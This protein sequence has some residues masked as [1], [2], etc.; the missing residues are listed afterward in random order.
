MG[1][2]GKN[3]LITATV[4]LFMVLGLLPSLVAGHGRMTN[5]PPR[6]KSGDSAANDFIGT[7]GPSENFPCQGLRSGAIKA[8]F[9]EGQTIPLKWH[10]S[11]AHDG[12]CQFELSPTGDSGFQNG[13]FISLLRIEKCAETVGDFERQVTLPQGVACQ[14]CTMRFRWLAQL[15]AKPY[16]NCADVTIRPG[17]GGGGGGGGGNGGNGGNRQQGFGQGQ[18]QQGGG[19]VAGQRGQFNSG[20]RQQGRS[21]R[22]GPRDL[23]ASE[24]SDVEHLLFTDSALDTSLERRDLEPRARRGGRKGGAR[25][26]GGA[27]GKKKGGGGGKKKGGGGGGAAAAAAKRKAAAANAKKKAAAAAAAKQKQDAAKNQGGNDAAA[28]AGGDNGQLKSTNGLELETF[29]KRSDLAERQFPGRQR[30]QA[31][32]AKKTGGAARKAGGAARKAGGGAGGAKKAAAGGKGKK[33]GSAG[34]KAKKGG[35]AGGGA[36]AAGAK[37]VGGGGGGRNRKAGGGGGGGGGAANGRNNNRAAGGGNRGNGGQFNDPFNNPN[38]PFNNPN[39][40]NGDFSGD[41]FGGAGGDN[42]AGAGGDPFNDPTNG[43][44]GGGGGNGGNDGFGNNGNN[45]NDPNDPFN[46]AANGGGVQNGD[47][48]NNPLDIGGDQERRIERL[49][50]AADIAKNIFTGVTGIVNAA[51]G[52]GK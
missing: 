4:G 23:I 51:T 45:F 7:E 39:A 20:Q 12:P 42:G 13:K 5:P 11:I 27:G 1:E 32:A 28:A 19:R 46:A 15:P 9:T 18:R 3:K 31:A 35:A 10:I 34:A 2:K 43:G 40:A 41:N 16:L 6:I 47:F 8:A 48:S 49:K 21:N 17:N 44:S 26:A 25:K 30:K 52:K 37:K 24:A 14:K 33:K 38:D 36:G 22:V 29:L 50:A